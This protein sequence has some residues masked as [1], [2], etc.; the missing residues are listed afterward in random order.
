MIPYATQTIE[1]ADLA[2]VR[3]VLTG[4]WLTQG[5]AVPRFE[6]AFANIHK[7][8]YACAVSSATAGLH[9]ACL[10]LGVGPGDWV[11]TSPIS[12]VASSNCALYCG[13]QVDFVDVGLISR[14]MSVEALAEKLRVAKRLGKLPKVVI[15][16]HFAGLSCDMAALRQ[17]ADE[18]GFSL[19]ADA[20][21][22]VGASCQGEPV[23]SLWADISVFSFH[24][25]KIITTAEGGMVVTNNAALAKRVELLRSHGITRD[26][27]QMQTLP[28]GAWYYEQQALGFNYRMTD[29]QAALGTAQLER[30]STFH[31]KREALA[32]NYPSLLANL[33]LVLPCVPDGFRSSWHL[34]AVQVAEDRARIFAS[35][36]EQGIGVNVHY[37]PIY[38]HPY[39]RR[40]S[41]IS[42]IGPGYCPNAETYYNGAISLPLYPL[43]STEQQQEVVHA[44]KQAIAG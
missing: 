16:V 12:F 24:P 25:V 26:A 38:L 27:A 37:L 32:A 14:N 34:Y 31:A 39:Q 43:L 29:I 2:A 40:V 30:L 10:A 7:V 41:S 15:P 23:G 17:L 18:Y 9:L 42:G 5:P 11:W 6:Q 21:H 1:D 13:A 28:E 20:S 8:S 22:A 35:L 44:L 4:D 36:R 3:A 33:G 19:L